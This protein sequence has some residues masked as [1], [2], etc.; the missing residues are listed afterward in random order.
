MTLGRA[1]LHCPD[2]PE[3]WSLRPDIFK[4]RLC[5]RMPDLPF[6][7][8]ARSFFAERQIKIVGERF[9]HIRGRALR[10]GLDEGF[11]R[12][13]RNDFLVPQ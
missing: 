9:Q 2:Q 10:A 3:N 11:D 6:W 1:D 4:Q 8:H 7:R 13:A 12:H 5:G